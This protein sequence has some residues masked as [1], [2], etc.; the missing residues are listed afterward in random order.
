MSTNL[1]ETNGGI[2][3]V[4][5]VF[6]VDGTDLGNFITDYLNGANL[7]GVSG[8]GLSIRYE[9][10]IGKPRL[11]CFIRKN[12][13]AIE[14]SKSRVPKRLAH[15]IEGSS[16]MRLSEDAKKILEPITGDKIKIIKSGELRDEVM[17]E[18]HIF[19]VLGLYLKA[20]PTNHIIRIIEAA[21]TKDR[22]K[23]I[24]VI[25]QDASTV[26]GGYVPSGNKHERAIEEAERRNRHNNW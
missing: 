14:T 2:Q 25:K 13:S 16:D 22:K 26:R 23:I 19:K 6:N 15:K 10:E 1:I 24:T 3:P 5:V 9:G 17:V 4:G 11:Y 8:A 21:E 20:N 7:S 18:L 12:S